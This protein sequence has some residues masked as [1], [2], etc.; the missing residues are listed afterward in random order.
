[1]PIAPV[2]PVVFS[3]QLQTHTGLYLQDQIKLGLVIFTGAVRHDWVESEDRIADNTVDDAEFSY[4]AALSYEFDSGVVPYLAWSRSFQPT[5]GADAAGSPFEPTTGEQTELGVKYDA[6]NAPPGVKMFATA[7]VYQLTQQNVL[8]TDP[9]NT[10]F[11]VQTGEVEV[12]GVELELVG[13]FQERLSLNASYTYT[14]SEVTKSGGPDL[15]NRLPVTPRHKASALVDYTFQDGTLAG[16]GGSL[17][18]RYTSDSAGNLASTFTPEVF[19]NPEVTLWDASVHYDVSDWRLAV[20]ASNLF[21]EEYVARCYSASN[22]FF[23]TRRIVAASAT[24]RF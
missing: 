9:S 13:R 6:R 4:R 2:A 1:M 12:K 20:T 19:I 24:R 7:A 16:L 11:Q 21:D 3:D 14:D 23:G 22:C 17:G 18:A 8:T 10:F 5:Q 15:G